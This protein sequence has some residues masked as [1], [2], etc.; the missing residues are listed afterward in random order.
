MKH[1]NSSNTS[2]YLSIPSLEHNKTSIVWYAVFKYLILDSVRQ[3]NKHSHVT[4][5]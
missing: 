5:V 3:K 1:V 4:D 2:K